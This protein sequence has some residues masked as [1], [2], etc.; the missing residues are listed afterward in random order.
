MRYT[1]FIAL[2]AGAALAAPVA[3]VDPARRTGV[4]GKHK[5]DV[6]VKDSV[7]GLNGNRSCVYHR[8]DGESGVGRVTDEQLKA[9]KRPGRVGI[10]QPRTKARGTNSTSPEDDA[11]GP[12]AHD[13]RSTLDESGQWRGVF[14]EPRCSQVINRTEGTIGAANDTVRVLKHMDCDWCHSWNHLSGES[15]EL[16]VC[17]RACR[18]YNKDLC[19][20]RAVSRPFPPF[21]SH[22]HSKDP[23]PWYPGKPSK[24]EMEELDEALKEIEKAEHAVEGLGHVLGL[25]YTLKLDNATALAR[26][27]D[28][29]TAM[30]RLRGKAVPLVNIHKR[31]PAPSPE[32]HRPYPVLVGYTGKSRHENFPSKGLEDSSTP[33]GQDKHSPEAKKPKKPKKPKKDKKDKKDKKAEKD[34]K[35]KKDKK[36]EKDNEDEEDKK[37]KKPKYRDPYNP[38]RPPLIVHKPPKFEH[39]SSG[40]EIWG[41]PQADKYRNWRTSFYPRVGQKLALRPYGK[42]GRVFINDTEPWVI[43][44]STYPRPFDHEKHGYKLDDNLGAIDE[45]GTPPRDMDHNFVKLPYDRRTRLKKHYVAFV[46]DRLDDWRHHIN[47]RDHLTGKRDV[48]PPASGPDKGENCHYLCER[49]HWLADE[50]QCVPVCRELASEDGKLASSTS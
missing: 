38:L 36:A 6:T 16:R 48:V 15:P 27:R 7:Q 28:N 21:T 41:P 10:E 47:G 25:N 29:S 8:G 30:G 35:D 11:D 26:S 2:I 22:A 12:Q 31:S 32:S 5:T 33:A 23:I 4:E 17:Y 44:H 39:I 42:W 14:G 3:Y 24:A 19:L 46:R 43:E 37:V 50:T 9:I 49:Q 20:G 18:K 40:P 34:K 13:K 1:L 45:V